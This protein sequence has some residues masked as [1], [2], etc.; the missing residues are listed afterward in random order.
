ME[1]WYPI[2]NCQQFPLIFQVRLLLGLVLTAL[3]PAP[4]LAAPGGLRLDGLRPI[5]IGRQISVARRNGPGES[6]MSGVLW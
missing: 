1:I 2:S 3:D 5:A 4:S 6:A